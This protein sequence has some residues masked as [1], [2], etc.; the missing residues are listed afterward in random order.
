MALL[1]LRPTICTRVPAWGLAIMLEGLSAASFKPL[2]RVPD[3]FLTLKTVFLLAISY[4]KRVGDFQAL[5]VTP[6]CFEFAPGMVNS[7]TQ[8]QAMS[9]KFFKPS[10]LL[11]LEIRTRKAEPCV[12]SESAGYLCPQSCP[13]CLKR[14]PLRQNRQLANG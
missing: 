10:V 9:L 7:F 8:S 1:R 12:S 14:G 13:L 3:K 6:S 5:S 11:F 2:E 4:L